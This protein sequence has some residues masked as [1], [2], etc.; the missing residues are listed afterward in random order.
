MESLDAQIAGDPSDSSR[1]QRAGP[2]ARPHHGGLG[3]APQL[4]RHRHL[5]HR[6]AP[7]AGARYGTVTVSII[8]L[9]QSHVYHNQTTLS[10]PDRGPLSGRPCLLGARPNSLT[11][12]QGAA[13]A[14][15]H[16]SPSTHMSIT[17]RSGDCDTSATGTST[18][19]GRPGSW[20]APHDSD[21]AYGSRVAHHST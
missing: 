6:T 20:P 11:L 10:E 5:L 9:R 19:T 16:W 4:R 1:A 14:P 3:S 12:P 21:M 17:R 15:R 13:P 2:D 8:A 7:Q 18:L